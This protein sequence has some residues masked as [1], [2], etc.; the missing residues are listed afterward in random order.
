MLLGRKLGILGAHDCD[1]SISFKSQWENNHIA[2]KNEQSKKGK[3]HIIQK[4]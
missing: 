4:F 1:L 3:V 2:I